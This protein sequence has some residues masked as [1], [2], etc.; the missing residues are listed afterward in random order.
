MPRAR[1]GA[2]FAVTVAVAGS[3][4]GALAQREAQWTSASAPNG[5]FTVDTPCAASEIAAL[6]RSPAEVMA[7]V[8]LAPEARV[9]CSKGTPIFVAGEVNVEGVPAGSSLFDIL[10][11]QAAADPTAEGRPTQ[12]RMHGRRAFVNRQERAGVIAQTGFVEI[13]RT[14]VVFLVSGSRDSSVGVDVQRQ[15]IDHFFNS[16]SVASE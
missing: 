7:G 11:Q 3:W 4:S 10:V 1:L 6:R 2:V 14:R 8:D 5:H 15:A 13:G 9:L 12:T 16:I